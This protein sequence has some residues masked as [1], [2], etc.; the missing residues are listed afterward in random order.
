MLLSWKVTK[1]RDG[2]E[3]L[4]IL[5]AWESF[6]QLQSISHFRMMAV[7]GEE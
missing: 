3:G 2:K 7:A 5:V 1:D 4:R 6:S